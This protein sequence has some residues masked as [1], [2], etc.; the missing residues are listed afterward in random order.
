MGRQLERD[1][2]PAVEPPSEY[3]ARHR[4]PIS[5]LARP[6]TILDRAR[7]RL[8]RSPGRSC[9]G[10]TTSKEFLWLSERDGWRHLYRVD[11]AGGQIDADH[12]RRF[13]RDRVARCRPRLGLGLLHRLAGQPDPALSLPRSA[14]RDAAASASTPADQAGTHDYQISPDAQWA[15]HE[16]SAFDTIPD[17][18][19]DPIAWPRAGPSTRGEQ[20]AS[21]QGRTRSRRCGRS[22]SGSTSATEY[23]R[24]LVHAAA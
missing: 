11:R 20:G 2:R 16:F 19:A 8:G 10:F 3:R 24:C 17:H 1:R 23:A 15:I 21:G 9:A 13:R 22:S 14:G 7:R 6:E 4:W 18:G 5:R 12:A